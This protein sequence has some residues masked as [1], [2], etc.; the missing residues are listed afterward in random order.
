MKNFTLILASLALMIF[1]GCSK[2]GD[3]DNNN[4]NNTPVRKDFVTA[5]VSG[6]PFEGVQFIIDYNP[7]NK[8]V[9]ITARSNDQITIISIFAYTDGDNDLDVMDPNEGSLILQIA[10]EVFSP[11]NG[12]IKITKNDKSAKVLEGE[13]SFNANSDKGNSRSVTGG[14]FSVKYP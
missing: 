4:N 7:D 2:G 3:D 5:S 12:N 10:D 9:E 8:F 11:Q 13:F 6:A 14:K 1:N